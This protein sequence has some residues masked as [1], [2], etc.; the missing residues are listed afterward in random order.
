MKY[1]FSTLVVVGGFSWVKA[2]MNVAFLT[3]ISLVV[4][5]DDT[6]STLSIELVTNVLDREIRR[7]FLADK[8][9][10]CFFSRL[11]KSSFL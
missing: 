2:A 6:N 9:L 11:M 1:C 4:D 3:L 5:Y 10:C 7:Y 8:D